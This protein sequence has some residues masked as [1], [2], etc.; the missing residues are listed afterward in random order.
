MQNMA[1]RQNCTQFPPVSV[2]ILGWV[3]DYCA[4]TLTHLHVLDHPNP[5][6]ENIDMKI[7]SATRMNFLVVA[8]AVAGSMACGSSSSSMAVDA[9]MADSAV[10]AQID[11]RSPDTAMNVAIDSMVLDLAPADSPSADA[12]VDVPQSET[13]TLDAPMMDAPMVDASPADT[14]PADG[15]G[16][17]TRPA[18]GAGADAVNPTIAR[19]EYLVRH[20]IGCSDCHTP[21]LPSGAPD[22]SKYLAGNPNFIVLPNGDRLPTRNLTPDPSGLGNYSSTDI[23]GMF[24]NGTV[25]ASTGDT[26][27]NPV[28]PYYVFH[29]M[30]AA[31][32]FA[33]A[34]YLQ[35][36]P[37]VANPLP[38]R[39]AS[40]NVTS[41]ATYLTPLSIPTPASTDPTY[42]S[43]IRGR[44]L[45][46]Q[47]GLCIECHTKHLTSG[48]MPLDIT[49]FFQGGEDFSSFFAGTLNITPV[50]LNITSDTTTGIGD[51]TAQ[52]IVTELKTG[53]DKDGTGIC[54]PM[55]VGPQ[56][57]YGGLT[58]T[59]ALD[60][61]NYI[62]SLPPA[63]NFVADMCTWPPLPPSDGGTGEAGADGSN[64]S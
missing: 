13:A 62:K 28:M 10:Y 5:Q 43:A 33:I 40:F 46:T 31:D 2:G 11:S 60:I 48:P 14:R 12:P 15:A 45:A 3:L 1:K 53:K 38:A 50:S 19:G 61:A 49:K 6:L 30:S 52:D 44:Y 32:A 26:A 59:D 41:P 51:W 24:L 56:G 8:T 55:P 25:P 47:T 64:G 58:D 17:D 27:L 39:S 18:D 21:N 29:N 20:V 22:F 35:S 57:A 23:E 16:A 34:V 9:A 4:L 42:A 37:A 63:V 7:T 54:P 36:I